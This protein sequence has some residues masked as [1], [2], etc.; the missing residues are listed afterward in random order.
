VCALDL[1]IHTNG[2]RLD[3]EVVRMLDKQDT[4][5]GISIDVTEPLCE[6][7]RCSPMTWAATRSGV[8]PPVRR[9]AAHQRRSQ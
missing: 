7:P 8:S 2:V 3:N 5:V 6:W 1:R 4:K 9:T